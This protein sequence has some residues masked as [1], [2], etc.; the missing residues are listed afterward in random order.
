M[1][2]RN[3]NLPKWLDILPEIV[4]NSKCRSDVLRQLKLTT[5]GSGNHSTVK[6]WIEKLNLDISHFD[7][8]KAI[9]DKMLNT[10]SYIRYIDSDFLIENWTGSITPIKRW[11][12]NNLK[13]QCELCNNI[14]THN[15]LPL[16]LQLDH[17]NGNNKDN[18][19]ENLRWL[20]PNCHTQT[21]TFAAKKLN[22]HREK[23]MNL[24]W[25]HQPRIKQRKVIW[26]SKEILEGEIKEFS[27]VSLGKK[28]GVSD[29]AIRKWCKKYGII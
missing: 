12:K 13:Y 14:G 19:V 26:P 2:I 28:Y 3:N 22:L 25:R 18:R 16:K 5:N 10:Y 1:N 11:A 15:N 17:K 20:C 9:S 23:K 29:N 4:K 8:R 7:Y 27:M 21:D 6:R 24:E